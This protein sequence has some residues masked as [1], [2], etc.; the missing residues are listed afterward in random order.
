[1]S[2]RAVFG[3]LAAFAIY[4]PVSTYSS[5]T[6]NRPSTGILGAAIGLAVVFYLLGVYL[7]LRITRG[8]KLTQEAVALLEALSGW[9]IIAAM[10]LIPLSSRLFSMIPEKRARLGIPVYATEVLL[11][12]LLL[13]V[14]SAA[15]KW[16]FAKNQMEVTPEGH[17]GD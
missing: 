14:V 15:T 8:P 4:V 3:A 12:C 2:R 6:T 7:R 11:L 10:V 17:D 13:G 16:F 5:V 9:L 1:M